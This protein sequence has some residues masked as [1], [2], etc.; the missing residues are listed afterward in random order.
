MIDLQRR[1]HSARPV[2]IRQSD[3]RASGLGLMLLG[4][5]AIPHTY[6]TNARWCTCRA[7]GIQAVTQTIVRVP[8][9]VR[10]LGFQR[11]RPGPRSERKD[12]LQA[13]LG[14]AVSRSFVASVGA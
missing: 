9:C 8:G 1:G 6:T 4:A 7:W 14:L 12:G 2:V 11:H 5:P 13:R 10:V 3:F